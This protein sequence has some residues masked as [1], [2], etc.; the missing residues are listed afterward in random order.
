[1]QS[2]L[3]VSNDSAWW[4]RRRDELLQLAEGQLNAYVYDLDTVMQSAQRLLGLQSIDRILFAMKANFHPELLRLL[5]SLNIDFECVS[6]GEAEH[7]LQSLPDLDKKRILFTPNFAPRA[8][9]AWS[10]DA[11]IQ[12][13]L[14]NLYPLQAWPELFAGQDI[15]VRVDPGE[16][17]GH[18]DHVKTAGNR[19]KFG[20]PRSEIDE[21]V[22]LV[23]QSGANVVGIHA[24]SG[25]GIP[26]SGSW[27][28]VAA[29]LAEVAARFPNASVLDLGGGFGVPDR[30]GA[31]PFDLQAMDE[32]LMEFRE[33]SPGMNLW[34]EPGR[35]LV[36]EAGI[37]LTHVT[38]T[39]GKG[40]R[41]YI[42][43]GT[44]M[45]SLIR[46]AL[47]G[48]YH[49]IVNLT[50]HEDAATQTANIVGLICETGDT[51]GV[52]RKMPPSYENDVIV[53]AN[54]GAYGRVMSSPYN[55]RE[56]PPEIVI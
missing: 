23:E 43:V 50:R 55:M 6:P 46:P 7:L 32:S 17:Y 15:F 40:E 33:S 35:Y 37:L 31:K 48:A 42:G 44:G 4:L 25:S 22:S 24:H 38:Q 9:Y 51:F 56:T 2:G 5:A 36:A 13:T 34:L 30:I 14:D 27:G 16:G 11:D 8:D 52:D 45:N 41:Q 18:H 49:E 54:T 12:V 26:E 19:S 47:Y 3:Q 29:R 1:M 53:I 20:I 10:R 28:S 39:K 21:L